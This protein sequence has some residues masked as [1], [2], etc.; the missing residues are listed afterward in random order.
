MSS[1]IYDDGDA[2]F[3]R[4]TMQSLQRAVP[5]LGGDT[6]CIYGDLGH[7]LCYL[8]IIL[9]RAG[10]FPVLRVFFRSSE[11][12]VAPSNAGD[13]AKVDRAELKRT[14]TIDLFSVGLMNEN[15]C[16][17][18]SPLGSLFLKITLSSQE[19]IFVR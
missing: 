11:P 13:P 4:G 10:S 9:L 17:S 8:L 15:C 6:Y 16:Y 19:T 5:P 18:Q 7:Q 1:I 14:R 12:H 3:V 2:C